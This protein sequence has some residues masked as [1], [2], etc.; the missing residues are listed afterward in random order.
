MLKNEERLGVGVIAKSSPMRHVVIDDWFH[1]VD[2]TVHAS[3]NFDHDDWYR[4]F[5]MNY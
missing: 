2:A 4:T 5:G 3:I 1:T